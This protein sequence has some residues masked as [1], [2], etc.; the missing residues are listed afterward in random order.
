MRNR[1]LN[2]EISFLL[3]LAQD[4]VVAG[5]ASDKLFGMAEALWEPDLEPDALFET[6]AQ[7]LINVRL[8]I[9]H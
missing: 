3:P 4:F 5:T 2:V 8:L 7:S 6:I 1:P 9:S